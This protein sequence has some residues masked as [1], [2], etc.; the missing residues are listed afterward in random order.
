MT[1]DKV[2]KVNI[3]VIH[4]DQFQFRKA[5]CERLN[6]L[7]VND[8]RFDVKFQYINE[9][10]PQDIT[11]DDIRQFVNYDQIKDEGLEIY[12]SLVKNLH[13]NQLSNALKHR[14][15]LEYIVANN[16]GDDYN[17]IIEDDVVF[18]DNICTTLYTALADAPENFEV[19]FL[20]LP[21]SKEAQGTKY[22]TVSDIFKI[23]PCC[24]S[25][26]VKKDV[27]KRLLDTY[28][29]IKFSNNIQLSYLIAKNA[30]KADL[31]VPNV[32]IDGSKLG[33]YFSSLEV[34]NRLIFNQDYV[35]LAKLVGDNDTYTP[36]DETV[37]DKLFTEVKLKTNPEFYYLKAIYETKRGNYEFAKR[38]YDYSYELFEA[39]G[40][41]IN[42]QST[43]LRDYMKVFKYTQDDVTNLVH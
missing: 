16:D 19:L 42:N 12:N 4:V 17:I 10:N 18:N 23:L 40:A 41:V 25:Y 22:Q 37:I 5:T 14:K 28:V 39:N 27:A 30:L 3:Y 31:T 38:I 21:S 11:N 26:V 8:T 33:L 24:D 32:F 1:M 43:F 15:A 9:Y 29:P 35:N 20:G 13:I 34:N 7:L 6:N 36:E 2:L